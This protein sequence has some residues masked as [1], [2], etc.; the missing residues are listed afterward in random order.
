M[1]K[2]LV[3]V[4]YQDM[5]RWFC[6]RNGV[7]YGRL[8]YQCCQG[9]NIAVASSSQSGNI[10]C[11]KCSLHPTNEVKGVGSYDY[12]I[13]YICLHNKDISKEEFINVFQTANVQPDEDIIIFCHEICRH[14]GSDRKT[15]D[16]L[17]KTSSYKILGYRLF[18]AQAPCETYPYCVIT[19]FSDLNGCFGEC[20][21]YSPV[22]LPSWEELKANSVDLA[23]ELTHYKF[24]INSLF[25]D[26]AIQC[27][28][29]EINNENLKGQLEE[30]LETLKLVLA[31]AKKD[32]EANKLS[33]HREK[34]NDTN[35]PQNFLKWLKELNDILDNIRIEVSEDKSNV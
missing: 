23:S 24:L 11:L 26:L 35:S 29:G 13:L 3:L 22:S 10:H 18:S 33:K 14:P 19:R 12:H 6:Q 15:L 25:F 1:G 2:W 28:E 7:N 27:H 16:D 32:E 4:G 31:G 30:C 20:K 9:L 17:Q 8:N 21:K 5:D 34:L